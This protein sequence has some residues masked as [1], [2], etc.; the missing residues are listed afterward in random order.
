[1]SFPLPP[2]PARNG[3]FIPGIDV[4]SRYKTVTRLIY[5][6]REFV[7]AR[8]PVPHVAESDDLY[9]SWAQGEWLD[10]L[11]QRF[12]GDPTLWWVI[13]DFNELTEMRVIIEGMQLRMP[14]ARRLLLEILPHAQ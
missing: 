1:M 3:P 6:N 13:A 12:Y 11:A 2:R 7:V 10:L 14:S 9:H 5:H 4:P 8:A